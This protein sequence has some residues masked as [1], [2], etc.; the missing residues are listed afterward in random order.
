MKTYS[1][2]RFFR[3]GHSSIIIKQGLTLQEAKEHCKDE[4]T[5][6]RTCYSIEAMTLTRTMGEW[7]DGY[8]EE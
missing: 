6:S 4:D 8:Q 2:I 5:S 1:I 7:F 3:D